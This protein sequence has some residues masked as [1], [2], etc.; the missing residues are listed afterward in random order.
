MRAAAHGD[1]DAFARLYDAHVGPLFAFCT[2]LTGDRVRAGELVQDTFVRAWEA[3]ATFRGDS[4]FGT[5]LH[6]IAVNVLLADARSA[7]RRALRVAIEADL[8]DGSTSSPLDG[9]ST[10]PPDV[11]GRLDLATA[12]DRLPKGARTVFLL[13]DIGGYTHAE[14][15]SLLGVAEGTCKAHLFRARR[16]LRGMLER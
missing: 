9:A 2:S 6:R 1:A 4:A 15:A 13:Y 11:A 8:A 10:M 16:L 3:L 14:I 12:V 5:W 7:H